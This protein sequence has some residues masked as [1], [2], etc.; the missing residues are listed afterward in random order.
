MPPSPSSPCASSPAA[1]ATHAC[2][3]LLMRAD[4]AG[5]QQQRE[6]EAAR[7]AAGKHSLG[8][9]QQQMQVCAL[10]CMRACT[11]AGLLAAMCPTGRVSA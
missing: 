9:L 2:M 7:R 8:V 5:L 10:A 4:A 3:Q 6:A 1:T 11:S